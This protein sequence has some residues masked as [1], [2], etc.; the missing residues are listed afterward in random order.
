[1]AKK[2]WDKSTKV[3]RERIR[4]RKGQEVTESRG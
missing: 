2:D 4:K 3:K 1:M